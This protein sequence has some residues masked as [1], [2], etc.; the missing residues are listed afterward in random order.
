MRGFSQ[1]HA[2]T[3]LALPN[4]LSLQAGQLGTKRTRQ[5][6]EQA[7]QPSDLKQEDGNSGQGPSQQATLEHAPSRTSRQL[8]AE[9]VLQN[10]KAG[11][12]VHARILTLLLTIPNGNV[13]S[14]YLTG[15]VN[16]SV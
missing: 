6:S 4:G 14:M 13:L 5:E 12:C 9:G 10:A 15:I 8:M 7:S 2:P 11:S 3:L 16:S 1:R